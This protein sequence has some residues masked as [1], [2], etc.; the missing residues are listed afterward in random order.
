[1]KRLLL[2]IALAFGVSGEI[3]SQTDTSHKFIITGM[4]QYLIM[5]GLRFDFD[6]RISDVKDRWLIA[7]THFYFKER[8]PLDNSQF[9]YSDNNMTRLLGGA[10]DL[11]LR[12]YIDAG[13]DP[14]GP[15]ISFGGGLAFFDITYYKYHWFEYSE[16]GMQFY[17]YRL[18]D[19]RRNI[20]QFKVCAQ[21]GYQVVTN[22]IVMDFFTGFGLKY[23]SFDKQ[24][25]DP[26]NLTYYYWSYGYSG[27]YM[28]LGLRLG[29]LQ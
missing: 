1:M 13:K 7:G 18:G 29:M 12:N 15:Y 5:N 9:S 2:C 22:D 21:I 3:I 20:S 25:G 24:R 16:N 26:R 4:P 28:T 17:D 19:F 11:Q 23:S 10:L 6:F 14:E 8:S 27:T